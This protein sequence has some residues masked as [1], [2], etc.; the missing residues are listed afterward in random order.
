MSSPGKTPG[1]GSVNKNSRVREGSAINTQDLWVIEGHVDA[2]D[3]H[4]RLGQVRPARAHLRMALKLI[5]KS[6]GDLGERSPER[7]REYL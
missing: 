7:L 5:R 6:I 1:S 3:N 2:A 4:L